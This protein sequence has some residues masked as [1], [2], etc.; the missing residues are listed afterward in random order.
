MHTVSCAVFSIDKY[1]VTNDQ[2]SAFLN[3]CGN[4]CDGYEC[5]DLIGH[6]RISYTGGQYVV[7]SGYGNHP[8]VE[9]TWY[10]ANAYCT[11]NGKRVPTE[12]V[13]GVIFPTSCVSPIALESVQAMRTM[14]SGFAAPAHPDSG[15]LVSVFL[16]L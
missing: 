12:A 11:E 16:K 10:G 8:V 5:V 4:D 13:R 15:F 9:F 6:I 14:T 1:E 3:K 7:N 2:I